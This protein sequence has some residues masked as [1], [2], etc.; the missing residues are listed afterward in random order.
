MAVKVALIFLEISN[1]SGGIARKNISS[2]LKYTFKK[3]NKNLQV[4][5]T[6]VEKD[7]SDEVSLLVDQP[8]FDADEENTNNS[9]NEDRRNTTN[10]F[11]SIVYEN[12][13]GDFFIGIA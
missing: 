7:P 11:D 6:F 8:N 4:N 10:D 13:I 3:K 5:E 2:F 9:N 12:S 1:V